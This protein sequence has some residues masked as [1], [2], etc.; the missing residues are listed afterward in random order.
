MASLDRGH[1]KR[2][3]YLIPKRERL[4]PPSD[5]DDDQSNDD[6]EFDEAA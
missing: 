6:P 5:P 2:D 3:L 4:V 1:G